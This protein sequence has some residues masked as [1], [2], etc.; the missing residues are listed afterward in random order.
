MFNL[1]DHPTMKE[2]PKDCPACESSDTSLTVYSVMKQDVR[3][4]CY[5]CNHTE[6]VEIKWTN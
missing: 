3:F 4:V 6:Q 1:F 2:K 5:K